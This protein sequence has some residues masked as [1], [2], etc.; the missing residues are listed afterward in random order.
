MLSL[1]TFV[2]IKYYCQDFEPF[3]LDCLTQNY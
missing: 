3:E 1:D 2:E